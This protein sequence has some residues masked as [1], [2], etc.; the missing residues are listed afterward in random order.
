MVRVYNSKDNGKTWNEVV[1]SE[2]FFGKR[3][4]NRLWDGETID[5]LFGLFTLQ[6]KTGTIIEEKGS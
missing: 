3:A 6:P 4:M 5:F 1:L 2:G